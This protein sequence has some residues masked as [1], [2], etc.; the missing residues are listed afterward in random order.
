MDKPVELHKSPYLIMSREEWAAQR[1][2]TPMTLSP[3]DVARLGGLSERLST[4]EVEEIYLPL[5]RLL[6]LYVSA[7]QELHLVTSRFLGKSELKVPFIIGIAGSVACGKS[8]TARV[9]KALLARWPGHPHVDL[10]STDGFLLPNKVLEDRK[11]MH[12]KGFPE[13][14][15][16]N[17]LLRFLA[18][19]KSGEPNVKAPIYSHFA[20]NIL[21]NQYV[22]ID[23]PDILVVE[24]LNVLQPAS[25]PKSGSAMPFV[26]DFFDVSVYIDAATIDIEQWY[27]ERFW[28]LKETA[29]RDP[30]AYFHK[31]ASLDDKEVEATARNIWRSINL[32]NLE[33]NILPTRQRADLI[34][35]K[36]KDH[37]VEEVKLRKL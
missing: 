23:R 1:R 14:F 16:T 29:F 34:L 11:I 27:I 12:R 18:D 7:S 2:D 20:Y 35:R 32:R 10:I 30:A 9:L 4:K 3:E 26:S 31:Y 25:M 19:V 15:D 33:K 6:S 21:E 36:S 8:T 5:S 28:R 24:G 37:A 13:S 17:R 22:S